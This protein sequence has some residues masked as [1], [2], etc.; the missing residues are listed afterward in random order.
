MEPSR[1][2]LYRLAGHSNVLLV[3]IC[4]SWLYVRRP[5]ISSPFDA[6]IKIIP[7]STTL[8]PFKAER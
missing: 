1:I 5:L 3:A 8:L 4:I 7:S 6:K 2:P